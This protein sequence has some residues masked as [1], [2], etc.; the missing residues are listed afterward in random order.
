MH[1]KNLTHSLLQVILILGIPLLYSCSEGDLSIGDGFVNSE[2]YT[3][4][5]DTFSLNLSTFRMDS[6]E[7]SG[8]GTA[9]CGHSK[10]HETRATGFFQIALTADNIDKKEKFDSLCLILN[11]SGYYLGDTSKLFGLNVHLLKEEITTNSSGSICADDSFKYS[12]APVG[13]YRYFPEP[14]S[15]EVLTIRLTDSLG[16]R[17]LDTLQTNSTLSSAD[18][19]DIIRGIALVS[20]T[21]ISDAIIGYSASEGN[22]NLR[23]YTHKVELEETEYTHDFPLENETLQFNHIETLTTNKALQSLRSHKQKIPELKLNHSAILQGGTGFFTRIDI[24]GLTSMKALQQEGQIVKAT[25]QVGVKTDQ[26]ITNTPPSSLYL[27]EADKINQISSYIVNSNSNTVTGSLSKSS[28]L[29]EENY[30]YTFDI[31]YFLNAL[32]N[33]EVTTE[34]TGI[35][36]ALPEEDLQGSVNKVTFKGYTDSSAETKLN[37]FYYNYD[38]E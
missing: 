37:V 20:D 4:I 38:K 19:E 31:T 26:N 12:K 36:L 17:L 2:T 33:E 21:S 5:T 22:I 24:T 35:V 27:L 8:T 28:S 10:T 13:S 9:L 23:L 29:Y 34:G 1:K 16:L 25:L 11:H 3:A 32:I 6:V 15:G 30:F 7:T 18:F 14:N